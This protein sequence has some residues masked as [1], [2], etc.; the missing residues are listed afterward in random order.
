MQEMT[1]EIGKWVVDGKQVGGFRNW[2]V[3][4]HY[5]P[6][7]KS[8]VIAS[9]WWML[10]KVNTNKL[11]ASF[12]VEDAGK[13]QLIREG[14]VIVNLPPD[15][16]LDTLILEPMKMAFETDFDWRK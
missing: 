9:G 13:F 16:A 12:Y 5:K 7:I 11:I 14:G 4:V 3:F 6:P 1:G 10:E 15:Y 2:T 8:W